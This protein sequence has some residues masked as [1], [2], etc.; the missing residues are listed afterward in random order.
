MRVLVSDAL[1]ERGVEILKKA[2]LKVD[3]KTGLS[4]EEL[5]NEI[6]AYDGLVIRS[7]TKVTKEV[8]AAASNLKVV[9]RAG[10]GLDNVDIPAA[11]KRGVV[12][13]NTPGGNTVTTA[14]H[15]FSLMVAMARR[16]PQADASTKSGKWEKKKFMGMEL[17]NKTLGIIGMGAIGSHVAKLAQGMMMNVVAYDAYLSPEK[18]NKM[19]VEVVD[20]E[21]LIARADVITIH[22]P[23]TAE[24]KHMIDAAAI[25]K[26][27][28]GV[29]IINCARGGI[30]DEDALYEG[31]KSGKVG[32]AALDVF[33]KEPVAPDH[34]LLTLENF[35]CTP[36]LGASTHEAQ[37]N[38]AIAVSNQLVDYLVHDVARFAV[39]LPSVPPDLL[40]KLQPYIILAEKIGSFIAQTGEG[41]VEEITI[42]YSGEAA[43]LDTA[44]ISVAVLKGLLSPALEV[45]VNYVNAPGI[46]KERGIVVNEVKRSDSGN[47]ASLLSIQVK[48]GGEDRTVTGAIFNKSEPRLVQID[49]MA[50][51]VIPEG[52]MLYLFNEDKPG[53]IG[54]LGQLLAKNQVN[55][56]SMQ[57]G[58]EKSGGK[59]ISV[60]GIDV[61]IDASVLAEIQG[62]PHVIAVK[63]V[64]M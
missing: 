30:V 16:V 11:T 48:T 27:K 24:T 19:G 52:T 8:V 49:Q 28:Q 55:I 33:E 58:R 32:G 13:M 44:P 31:L 21:T 50:L 29:R 61:E 25:Q 59:A 36:H 15:A 40:P 43:D 42:T 35:I 38:V 10:S 51:E 46:A 17:F 5:I 23:L 47:F 2:G 9:G 22:A 34:P 53:V 62:L 64:K 60:V 18:A 63:Q 4:P 41:G 6:P 1:A 12:V 20:F 54:G 37:E 14:E 45:P 3:V 57:L 56:S 7:A 26:M 39:N